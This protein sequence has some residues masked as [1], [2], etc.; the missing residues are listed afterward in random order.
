MASKQTIV[1]KYNNVFIA[2]GVYND[3]AK[4]SDLPNDLAKQFLLERVNA[5]V[6]LY[7]SNNMQA[8]WSPGDTI[9]LH[10]IVANHLLNRPDSTAAIT[11]VDK[12]EKVYSKM[13]DT[14]SDLISERKRDVFA[15]LC[16]DIKD[17][18]YSDLLLSIIK[19]AIEIIE[20]D[21]KKLAVTEDDKKFHAILK[22]AV[23]N[24]LKDG[25]ALIRLRLVQ[26]TLCT[27]T[28]KPTDK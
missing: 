27:K 2:A 4:V 25:W 24:Q 17:N 16:D 19:F 13:Y 21:G 11:D 28:Q 20:S 1:S 10:V 8:F 22:K 15:K 3:F 5:I 9:A 7:E 12:Y 6:V 18:E 23:A 14:L 26:D